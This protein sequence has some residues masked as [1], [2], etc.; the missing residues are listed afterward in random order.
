MN[1]KDITHTICPRC[2]INYI[3]NNETPGAYPGAL[4]RVDNKTEICSDC[5][6]DEA[7]ADYF[8]SLK[9]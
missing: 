7:L 8:G 2:E 4:S 1:N 9:R 6:V 3:P 5:G